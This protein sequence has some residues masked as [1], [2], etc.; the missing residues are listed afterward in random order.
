[1]LWSQALEIY[2]PENKGDLNDVPCLLRITDMEG[3][4]ASD[5]ITALSH[6]WY[7]DTH[8]NFW[9]TK[10]LCHVYWEGCF[11]GGSIVHL[12]LKEGKYKIF[13][14]TPVEKQADYAS[15]TSQSWES[16]EFVYNTRS[17]ELKVIFVSPVADDSGF[18]SGSWHID[19]RA[20]KFYKW[21]K[22]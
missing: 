4:D 18:F 14:Y 21:T 17:K 1:M 20:P 13:V 8:L 10:T 7:Y 19:Y 12:G 3:N 11:T 9:Q 22:Q 2:R 6:S 16:N 5:C 15:L